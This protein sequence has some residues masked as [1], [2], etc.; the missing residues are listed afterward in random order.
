MDLKR[1]F[2]NGK[3]LFSL[4]L[5]VSAAIIYVLFQRIDLRTL[6]R[7]LFSVKWYYFILCLI[8]FFLSEA[9]HSL[10]WKI[11]LKCKNIEIS[12]LTLLYFNFVGLFYNLCLPTAIGGDTVRMFKIAKHSQNTP[13]A[14]AS[15][16]MERG[17]G[18]FTLLC[19]TPIIIL[20]GA[21][22]FESTV[23]FYPTLSLLFAVLVAIIIFF[24]LKTLMN[25]IR[26]SK[27]N[28]IYI[29]IGYYYDLFDAYRNHMKSILMAMAISICMIAIVIII[30]FLISHGLR[31]YISLV[32]FIV[33]VP[34]IFLITMIPISIHGLGLR[35]GAFLFLFAKAGLSGTEA[36]SISLLSYA[37]VLIYGIIGGIAHMWD[38]KTS[39]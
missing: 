13:E 1:I 34:I 33:F 24:R 7:N 19:V 25:K 26:L 38:I 29:K 3:F 20:F 5:L 31:L 9:L 21:N 17:I 11:L 27:K 23:L 15:V 30:T 2:N 12:I 37:I 6:G 39:N 10:R 4:K 35:E 14:I 22:V 28:K 32:Y 36:I 8:L 16:F 18:F